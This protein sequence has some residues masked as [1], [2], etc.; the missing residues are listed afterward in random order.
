MLKN[1]SL[2]GGVIYS[3]KV[4]L[5]L[6]E[7]GYTREDAYRIVQKHALDALNG[8]DFKQALLNDDKVVSKLSD[9]ELNECFN[10]SDYLINIDK[11]F[12]RFN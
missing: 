4:L 10:V 11:V 8:G 12:E 3:Q 9:A 6:V 2:Y 7:K 5:K 1:T